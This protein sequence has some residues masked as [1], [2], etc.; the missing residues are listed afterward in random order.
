MKTWYFRF[1]SVLALTAVLAAC[2]GDSA[3][4][5]SPPTTRSAVVA[6]TDAVSTAAI[7]EPTTLPLESTAE[8]AT[9]GPDMATTAESAT[10]STAMM[11]TSAPDSTMESTDVAPLGSEV[12]TVAAVESVTAV[13]GT[14]A[15]EPAEESATADT[16]EEPATASASAVAVDPAVTT[17]AEAAT[18]APDRWAEYAQYTI[19]GLRTR[20]YG[21]GE[22]EI[23]QTLEE[24][25][26]FTRYLI[27]YPS[28]GLRLTGML[29]RPRGDGP[30]PVVILNHGYYALDAYQT[31]N[32]TKLA[33]DYLAERGY[34]T[35]SPDFRSHAGSDDAQT[36]SGRVMSSTRLTYPNGAAASIGQAGQSRYVGS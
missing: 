21:E 24:A 31:G 33:A 30:F 15:V 17:V 1:S 36:S 3:A 32:G 20:T 9:A 7:T 27:A 11:G 34:M 25:Q 26:N 19:E 12:A 28:D 8:P 4:D 35:L 10:A 13:G 14:T 5:L 29:N 6:P 18:A 16:A 2:G 23:V 22:I